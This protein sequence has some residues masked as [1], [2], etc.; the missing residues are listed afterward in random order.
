MARGD[1]I[2][3]D[4]TQPPSRDID[5]SLERYDPEPRRDWVRAT[6]TIGLVVGFLALLGDAAAA[7]FA[8]K[9]H[10]EQTKEM[11]Q[12]LLPALTGLLGSALGFYFGT[13]S[14]ERK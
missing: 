13:K 6:V 9:D 12:I 7:A 4:L 11:L 10:F 5:V 2:E 8:T 1:D 3:I 14:A